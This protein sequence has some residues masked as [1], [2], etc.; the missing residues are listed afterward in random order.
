MG[1]CHRRSSAQKDADGR[2]RDSI[3]NIKKAQLLQLCFSVMII[4]YN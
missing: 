2:D 1:L 3:K 4:T